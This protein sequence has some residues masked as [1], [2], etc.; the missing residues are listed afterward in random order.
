[1]KPTLRKAL[2][3]HYMT[4]P[5]KVFPRFKLGAVIFLWGLIVIYSASQLLEPSLTQEVFTLLGLIL[6]GCGL[7]IALMAQVR[8]LIGRILRVLYVD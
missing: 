5:E 2:Y 1:M 4:P 3:Q 7:I 6:I 8:M